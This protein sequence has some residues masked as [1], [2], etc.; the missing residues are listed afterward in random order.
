MGAQVSSAT[1]ATVVRAADLLMYFKDAPTR[2]LGVSEIADGLGMSKAATHRM[3]ASLRVRGLIELD[4]TTRRYSL[5]IGIMQLGL[6]YME[7]IDIRR[8]AHPELVRLSNRTNETATLSVRVDQRRRIYV[9]E[10]VPRRE[11]IMSV[12][13]GTPYPLHAGAS[14]KAFLAFFTEDG[15]D[16]YLEN[17][18]EPVTDGTI[19]DTAALLKELRVVRERGWAR[20]TGERRSGAASVAAPV[21][22]HKGAVTAVISVCGPKER[23]ESEFDD[24]RDA[25]L[26]STARLSA[27]LGWEPGRTER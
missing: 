12:S 20:S 7:H 14:S 3:L 16:R 1:I 21:F 24:C 11:V 19:T 5:G 25:L 4:E 15:I 13:L 27:R 9:D 10:V 23:F 6:A 17:A 8:M 2:D 22:D 18:L 26:E